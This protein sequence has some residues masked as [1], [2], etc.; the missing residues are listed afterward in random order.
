MSKYFGPD[1]EIQR[2]LFRTSFERVSPV[3]FLFEQFHLGSTSCSV[4]VA[5]PRSLKYRIH[6]RH[7]PGRLPTKMGDV[8]GDVELSFEM[9]F[10]EGT[11]SRGDYQDESPRKKSES[12]IRLKEYSASFQEPS[13]VPLSILSTSAPQ[14][15][16]SQ[17]RRTRSRKRTATYKTKNL[18]DKVILINSICLLLDH[19]FFFSGEISENLCLRMFLWRRRRLAYSCAVHQQE[20]N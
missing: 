1:H 6:F 4:L 17:K 5:P 3:T 9:T 8:D 11:P 18:L 14:G 15:E 10:S 13:A 2:P 19:A 16:G 12:E 20:K 7:F